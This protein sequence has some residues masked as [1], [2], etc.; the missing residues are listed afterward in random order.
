MNS[1]QPPTDKTAA[2]TRASIAQL[3]RAKKRAQSR[4]TWRA[5]RTTPAPTPVP[6]LWRAWAVRGRAALG[7]AAALLRRLRAHPKRAYLGAFVALLLSLVVVGPDARLAA[8]GLGWALWARYEPRSVGLGRWWWPK[9]LRPTLA[10]A[11]RVE[12]VARGYGR[13]PFSPAVALATA[14]SRAA[15]AGLWA[16][17]EVADLMTDGLGGGA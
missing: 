13:S 9:D 3:Q 2:K 1:L 8:L 12:A 16:W 17:A 14:L 5:R 10:R 6:V 11:L 15:L 4:D 7:R